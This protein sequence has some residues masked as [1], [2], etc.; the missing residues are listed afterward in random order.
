MSSRV[1]SYRFPA[2][3]PEVKANNELWQSAGT[4]NGS[5]Y[6]SDNNSSIIIQIGSNVAFM[7]TTQ[8]MLTFDVRL[9]DNLGVTVNAATTRNS[10][11]SVSRLFSR[12]VLRVGSAIIEDLAY[13]DLCAIYY[14][15]LTQSKKNLLA[16]TEGYGSDS[17]F[18]GAAPSGLKH[19]AMQLITSLFCTEQALPLPLFLNSAG[20]SIELFLAPLTNFLTV[21]TGIAY[22]EISQVALKYQSIIPD[23]SFTT[24]LVS[25]VRQGR[26]AVIPFQFV[27]AFQSNGNAST[28]QSIVC[29]VGGVKSVASIETVFFDD[30]LYNGQGNDRYSRFIPAGLVDWRIEAAGI[31]APAMLTFPAQ[32]NNSEAILMNFLSSHGNSYTLGDNFAID[33]DFS[34]T[35]WRLSHSFV[36]DVELFGSGLDMTNAASPN[37]TIQTTHSV[38]L[39]TNI[40]IITYVTIDALLIISGTFCQ[41]AYTW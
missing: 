25:S 41:V 4:S 23:A 11:Q 10:R 30:T 17:I 15:T 3:S 39:P 36:S 16:K 33:A 26:E 14:S 34:T 28:R 31:S 18:A 9:C 8:S 5:V 13:D 24:Q 1:L 19:F 12:V 21:S 37:I 7:K 32:S 38:V 35:S 40:R 22:M 6:R 2:Y 20:F 27:R 29:P